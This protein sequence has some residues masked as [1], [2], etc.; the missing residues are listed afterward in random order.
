MNCYPKPILCFLTD[1]EQTL[2]LCL[3]YWSLEKNGTWSEKVTTLQQASGRAQR[4]L[5]ALIGA[6]CRLY[7]MG[8]RCDDCGT[9]PEITSRQ[10]FVDAARSFVRK[11]HVHRCQKCTQATVHKRVAEAVAEEEREKAQVANVLTARGATLD[12]VDYSALGYTAAFLLY[13]VLRAAG[14]CW[15]GRQITPLGT[16]AGNLAPTEEMATAIY[17]HLYEEGIIAPA[18]SW[19]SKAYIIVDGVSG[20]LNFPPQEVN[21]ALAL[22]KDGAP[23]EN[24]LGSLEIVLDQ[25]DLVSVAW[26]WSMV[27]EAECERYFGELCERY[28]FSKEAIFS[29]KVAESIRYC[30]ERVSLAKVWNVLWYTMREIAALIQEGRY[31]RPHVY[32]MVAGN[33]RRDID[34]R[35]ANNSPIRPW[36]R[37]RADKEPI[38]T[39]ILFDKILGKGTFAFENVTAR[40]IGAF[41]HD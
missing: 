14:E 19:N 7:I 4:D 27:A 33:L 8:I 12:P 20:T 39:G 22:P 37:L 23:I 18:P 41:F 15:Q 31:I 35:L 32:N 24:V 34:R 2:D 13:S 28:R 29:P 26:L 36:N 5:L 38:I 6:S 10:Q 30:L 1:N 25:R 9:M 17:M 40:N 16:Q 3:W 11:G 21:W